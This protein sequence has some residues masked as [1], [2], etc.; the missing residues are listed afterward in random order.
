MSNI[1]AQALISTTTPAL[2]SQAEID[3]NEMNSCSKQEEE[4]KAK[5]K[6]SNLF[7]SSPR[8][9]KVVKMANEGRDCYAKHGDAGHGFINQREEDI[10]KTATLDDIETLISVNM[11]QPRRDGQTNFYLALDN[12]EVTG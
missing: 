2:A 9:R 12:V 11:M 7:R 5:E 8:F 10:N 1:V 4:K 6:F 3:R